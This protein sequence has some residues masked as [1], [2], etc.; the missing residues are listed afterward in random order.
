MAFE[1]KR[2]RLTRLNQQGFIVPQFPQRI[3]DGVEGFPTAGGLP[4]AAVNHKVIGAFGH[5]RVQVSFGSCGKLLRLSQDLH[6]K[7]GLLGA[8]LTGRGPDILTP[9]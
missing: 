2:T 3:Q 7:S 9:P 8:A 4:S 1:E 5:L 6:V